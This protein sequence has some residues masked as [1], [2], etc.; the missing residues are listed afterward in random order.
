[1][2]PTALLLVTCLLAAPVA[3]AVGVDAGG[4]ATAPAATDATTTTATATDTNGSA[5]TPVAVKAQVPTDDG[6]TRNVTVLTAADVASV[7]SVDVSRSGQPFV[8]VTLTASGAEA[9]ASDLERLG[10][11]DRDGT[12]CADGSGRCLHT[13]VDGEV[14]Y[15]AG[16][17]PGLAETF[18]SGEFVADPRFRFV[19]ANE[20][21]A[22]DLA[23]A[24]R[25]N[26]PGVTTTTG[27]AAS[28]AAATPTTAATADGDDG[29]TEGEAG[30]AD[31]GSDDTGTDGGSLPGFGAVAAL[32]ALCGFLVVAHRRR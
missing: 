20:S 18:R 17:S 3:G 26:A 31:A 2:R 19:T 1:M 13:V 6:G 5:D 12:R 21:S 22:R 30:G 16:V 27:T 7:G 29:A 15:S 9:F 4:P 25:A 28:D 11:A 10:F 8:T 23:A 24:L 14:V 32:A